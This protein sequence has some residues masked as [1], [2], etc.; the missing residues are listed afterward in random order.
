VSQTSGKLDAQAVAKAFGITEHAAR[1]KIKSI[2]LKK[3]QQ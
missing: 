3:G 1:E 2:T